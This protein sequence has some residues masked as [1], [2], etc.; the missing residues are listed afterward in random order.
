MRPA[1]RGETSV[2]VSFVG[3]VVE[4]AQPAFAK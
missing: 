4:L 2:F 3:F 1:A